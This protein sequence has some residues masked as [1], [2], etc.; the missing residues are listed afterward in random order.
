M[1]VNESN[2]RPEGRAGETASKF[3][4]PSFGVPVNIKGAMALRLE[5]TWSLFHEYEIEIGFTAKV[6][7]K[8]EL[9]PVLAA[10]ITAIDD[11]K[12]DFG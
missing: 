9:P 2:S 4:E 1:P 12:I 3:T 11:V 10:F 6:R 5:T 8:R 7:E